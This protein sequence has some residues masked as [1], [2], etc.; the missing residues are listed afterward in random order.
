MRA[1]LADRVEVYRGGRWRAAC[2]MY[3]AA[4]AG[5]FAGGVEALLPPAA[6]E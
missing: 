6:L 3:L 5:K 2:D 1:V 4:C